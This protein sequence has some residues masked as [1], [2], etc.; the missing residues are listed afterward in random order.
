MALPL[1]DEPMV[2]KAGLPAGV[3]M[4]PFAGD[5]DLKVF[6]EIA[7]AA[8]AEDRVEERTSFDALRNWV[9]HPSRTFDAAEDVAVVTLDHKPIAYGWTTWVDSSDGVRDY[10]T[11]GHV[12]PAW[13]R[14]GIGTAILRRNEA[15]LRRLAAEHAT[16]R[17]RFYTGFAPDTRLG[18]VALLKGQGYA[19]VRYFYLA[20]AETLQ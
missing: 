16:D 5:E 4:R 1:T 7:N 14:R 17:P 3:A 18:A 19:P 9:G 2:D 6:V 15:R 20:A 13:R 11:R 12:H 8:N 10:S